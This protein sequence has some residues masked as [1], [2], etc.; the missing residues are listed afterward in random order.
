CNGNWY[1]NVSG[2]FRSSSGTIR[3]IFWKSNFCE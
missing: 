1:Y 2:K 3:Y